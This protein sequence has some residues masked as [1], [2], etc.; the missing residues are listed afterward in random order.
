MKEQSPLPNY[1]Q[2]EHGLY[3]QAQFDETGEKLLGHIVTLQMK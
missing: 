2:D 3:N 1:A